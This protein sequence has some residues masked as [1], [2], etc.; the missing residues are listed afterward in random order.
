MMIA[1]STEEHVARA[2]TLKQDDENMIIRIL[3]EEGSKVHDHYKHFTAIVQITPKGEGS[4]VKWTV[5]FEK[6]DDEI[7]DPHVYL[8]LFDTITQRVDAHVHK[9]EK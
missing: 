7:P 3:A 4:L 2:R 9:V 1:G 6:H 8:E 5:E